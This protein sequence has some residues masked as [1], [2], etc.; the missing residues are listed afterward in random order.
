MRTAPN[1]KASVKADAQGLGE[2]ALAYPLAIPESRDLHAGHRQ[3]RREAMRVKPPHRHNKTGK[4]PAVFKGFV[5]LHYPQAKTLED[6]TYYSQ[7]NQRDAMRHGVEHF[8]RS[9]YCRGSLI[10]QINDCWPIQSWAMED[11]HRLLKPAGQEMAR[12]YAPTLVSLVVGEGRTE[13]WLVHDGPASVTG[14]LRLEAVDTL[15]GT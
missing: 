11:Y 6:W 5:E 3:R 10:W 4:T 1:R 13:A 8:R 7:L 14:T 2:H 15:D 9:P 12:V